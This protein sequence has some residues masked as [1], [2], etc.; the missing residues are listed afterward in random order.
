MQ[1]GDLNGDGRPDL[2][3]LTGG[4]TVSVALG[5]GD[6][7][8]GPTSDYA[9]ADYPLTA[10]V[11]DVDGDGRPD[12]LVVNDDFVVATLLGDG[13]GLFGVPVD[14]A[15]GLPQGTRVG[16]GDL[17]GDGRLDVAALT[18][19]TPPVLKLFLGT[20]SGTLVENDDLPAADTQAPILV[21]DLD[22]DGKP[23]L[24]TGARSGRAVR[25]WMGT[26]AGLFG[27]PTDVPLPS[28]T[29]I[30]PLLRLA[31]PADVDGDGTLDLIAQTDR[32]VILPGKGDGTFWCADEYALDFLADDDFFTADLNH[33]GRADVVVPAGGVT[34]VLISH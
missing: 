34:A 7:Q 19:D 4:P 13:S 21:T 20:S 27:S 12:L 15:T 31:P 17:D 16:I 24:V 23:D 25:I 29:P 2:V 33:D 11:G 22:R 6:G 14:T 32:L 9:L 1:V 26:G 8:L 5:E 30:A 10:A 18:N 28:R 3:T